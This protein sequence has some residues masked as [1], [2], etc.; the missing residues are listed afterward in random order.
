MKNGKYSK[1][2][3]VASKTL[4]LAL[5]VMLIVGATVGGT[6]A[7]L[8][9]KTDAVVNTFTIGDVDIAL[10]ETR[11]NENGTY[12]KEPEEGVTNAYK[13]IPGTTY[14]KD[15]TVTVKADSE[16]CYL[17]VRFD[18]I[19]FPDHYLDYTST[20][21]IENGWNRV[22]G[23][24]LPV[25]YREVEA[26]DKDQSWNLLEYNTITVNGDKVTK[27]NMAMASSAKLAYTAYAVQ[28]WKTNKPASGASDEAIA[29][30]KFTPAEA[31]AKVGP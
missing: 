25:W 28:L 19:N 4:V 20:L 9:D 29:A 5:A 6:I 13:M 2:R 17:F 23:E 10:T 18:E 8:T 26:S 14:K 27:G 1:R 31:W 30:A 11:L 3:G 16:D 15:P 22:P 21:T 7:W 12:G 24:L